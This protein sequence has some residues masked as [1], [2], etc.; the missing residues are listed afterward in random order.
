M[1]AVTGANGLVGSSI[2][3][4][5]IHSG[6][7][8]IGVKRSDSDIRCLSHVQDRLVW[9]NANLLDPVS[10]EDAFK[11]VTTV[12]HAAAMVSFNPHKRKKILENNVI[13]T[14]NV[15]N[16]ALSCGATRLIHISSVA[17]L[18]RQKGQ[19]L[20]DETNKWTESPVNSTYGESKYLS[21][22]E[23][24]R[25]AEEGISSVILNPSV[26]LGTGDWSKSSSKLFRYV[27]N[28]GKY[29]VDSD[30]NFVDVRDVVRAAVMMIESN[31]SNERFILNGGSTSFIDFFSKIAT[32]FNKHPPSIKL[33][34]GRLKV[35]A[36]IESLR[37]RLFNSEPLIT[38]ETARLA[39]TRFFYSSKKIE[40]SFNFRFTPLAETLD[41]C[42]EY[43]LNLNGKK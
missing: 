42:T 5:L 14:R 6:I 24:F 10:L 36:A 33:S 31:V 12:I 13:G 19:T 1:I 20:I 38:S 4:E 32:R 41:W 16:A 8:C 21:E 18:G 26:I 29:Y 30:L 22:L 25:A 43:Y 11:G 3:T 34:A 28:E 39:D 7:P 9:R 40:D 15:V 23:V 35:L 37:A 27:W 17:A 2:V